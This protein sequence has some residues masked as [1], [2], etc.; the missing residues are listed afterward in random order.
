MEPLRGAL[1]GGIE[2]DTFCARGVILVS[3]LGEIG[4]FTFGTLVFGV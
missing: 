2:N 4:A 1:N 3:F